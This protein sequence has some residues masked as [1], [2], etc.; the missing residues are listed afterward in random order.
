MDIYQHMFHLLH[1]LACN[2]HLDI[3]YYKYHHYQDY[4][5]L[6]M[7]QYI[8]FRIIP[9]HFLY[10]YQH[11]YYIYHQI[12]LLLHIH[13]YDIHM[14]YHRCIQLYYMNNLLDRILYKFI[15]IDIITYLYKNLN[16][17]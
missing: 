6:D 5:L 9:I 17:L 11:K 13:R 2:I 15:R 16:I 3:S 8:L 4:I 12:I 14:Y 10:N 1:Y 7:N